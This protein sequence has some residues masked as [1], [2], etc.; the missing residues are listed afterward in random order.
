[1]ISGT[2]YAAQWQEYRRRRVRFR[3]V[4]LATALFWLDGSTLFPALFA[5]E[6]SQQAV[7][8]LCCLAASAFAVH[9]YHWRCPRCQGWFFRAWLGARP[10]ARHCVHCGL[11]KW[12]LSPAEVQS[13]TTRSSERRRGVHPFSA[14]AFRRPR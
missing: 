8:L 9:L 2:T 7:G 6:H 1:M 4:F 5:S 14:R 3:L 12:A 10:F 11:P 13:L